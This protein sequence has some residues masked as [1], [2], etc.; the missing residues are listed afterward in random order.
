MYRL[1]KPWGTVEGKVASQYKKDMYK[2]TKR[3]VQKYKK[4]MY[5][6]TK[7]YVQNYAQMCVQKYVQTYKA[8]GKSWGESCRKIQLIKAANEFKAN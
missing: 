7:R 1:T 6:N 5:K 8:L 4:D 3:Y 2:N